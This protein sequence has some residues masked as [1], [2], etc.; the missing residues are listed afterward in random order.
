MFDSCAVELRSKYARGSIRQMG[1]G[2][3]FD[4]CSIDSDWCSSDGCSVSVRKMFGGF[5]SDGFSMMFHRFLFDFHRM[6]FDRF[7]IDVQ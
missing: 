5:P 2:W 4:R 3:M 6:D 7:S 1:I